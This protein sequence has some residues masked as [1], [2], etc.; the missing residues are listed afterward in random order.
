MPA[1]M[2]VRG[3]YGGASQAERSFTVIVD[4][5]RVNGVAD[6]I[7]TIGGKSTA[8][9]AKFTGDWATS[10]RNP[11]S[12]NG[13]KPWAVAEQ[14]KMVTQA[15]N[16]EAAF[17]GGAVYHT[18]ST[19]LAQHYSKAFKDAGITKFEFIVTPTK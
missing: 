16:Y 2:G 14:Q 17:D 18:N 3:L 5:K 11:N 8:V 12:V 9:D 4:G 19:A 7:T 10:L 15:K 6:D 1:V 13:A